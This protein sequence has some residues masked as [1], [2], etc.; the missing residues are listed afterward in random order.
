MTTVTTRVQGLTAAGPLYVKV[1]E[2]PT[3]YGLV[4][5]EMTWL[6]MH[7]LDQHLKT[8]NTSA[9]KIRYKTFSLENIKLDLPE[10]PWL[11][12]KP[13]MV[14]LKLGTFEE[15]S[16]PID[17][18]SHYVPRAWA[19]AL[20]MYVSQGYIAFD[21]DG[22][23]VSSSGDKYVVVKYPQPVHDPRLHVSRN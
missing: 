9:E 23:L 16:F 4:F 1:P 21:G 12:V 17:S 18:C 7:S 13:R 19:D 11:E 15:F 2:L 14:E 10:F 6:S 5:G 22:R 8:F 20:M 3:L